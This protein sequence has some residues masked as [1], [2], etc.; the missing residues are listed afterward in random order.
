MEEIKVVLANGRLI[1]HWYARETLSS[2]DFDSL[3]GRVLPVH[4]AKDGCSV[5][6]YE[7]AKALAD[8][9]PLIT[10]HG[11]EGIATAGCNGGTHN[12]T[13]KDDESVHAIVNW[14]KGQKSF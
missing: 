1:K 2:F 13:G 4:H 14:V 10:V 6:P 11:P 12:L 5:T 7:D 3:K 8:R 9:I